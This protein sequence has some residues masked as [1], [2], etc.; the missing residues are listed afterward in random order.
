MEPELQALVDRVEI[1]DVLA[2]YARGIDRLDREL[3]RG[4]Y[5]DDAVDHHGTFEGTADEFVDWVLDDL[6]RYSCTMHFLGQ[7]LIERPDEQQPIAIVETYA[8]AFSAIDGGA[9]RDNWITGFR[10][11]DRFERRTGVDGALGPWRIAER[12]I[13]GEWLR[14]DPLDNHRRFGAD[15]PT[16]RRDGTDEVFRWLRD[17]RT[18]RSA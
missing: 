2:R 13:L 12:T 15:V 16:G 1:Q 17:V 18:E 8:L 11:L 9:Q 6:R 14:I 10:Y 7:T 5:H 4:C 3:I